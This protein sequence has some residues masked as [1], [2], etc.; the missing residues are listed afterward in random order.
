MSIIGNGTK[1]YPNVSKSQKMCAVPSGRCY[2]RIYYVHLGY[3]NQTTSGKQT[4]CITD[5]YRMCAVH[6]FKRDKSSFQYVNDQNKQ[7]F[8][9]VQSGVLLVSIIVR[10]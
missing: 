1:I 9:V 10:E 6:G 2:I 8:K 5:G 4:G 3:I 7:N